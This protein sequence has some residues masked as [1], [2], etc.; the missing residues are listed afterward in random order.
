MDSHGAWESLQR[1]R[2]LKAKS[3]FSQSLLS[4]CHRDVVL[5]A[6][7]LAVQKAL[8]PSQVCSAT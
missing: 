5:H 3:A 2:Q 4:V 8:L 6:Q 1:A 7:N